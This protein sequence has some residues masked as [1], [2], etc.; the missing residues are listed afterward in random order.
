VI[1]RHLQNAGREV[2]V[3]LSVPESAIQGDPL[4]NYRILRNMGVDVSVH[5]PASRTH[6]TLQLADLVVDAI[7]GTGFQG[8]VRS[9]IAEL[10]SA[11]N[12]ARK[13]YTVAIDVPSGLDC[14]T[15]RP[16]GEAIRADLTVTFVAPKVGF[17]QPGAVEWTGE[18]R[19][20]GI[21]TPPGLVE[22]VR[23]ER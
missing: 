9:P 10:I 16:G 18:V 23:G 8:Q 20:V 5:G 19:V 15:G 17:L 14:D 1:A 4:I 7:L 21:G 3:R 2:I 22:R 13:G 12:A 6:A 11:I